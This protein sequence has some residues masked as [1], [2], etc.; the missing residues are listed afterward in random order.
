MTSP[1]LEA[2]DIEGIIQKYSPS[3]TFDDYKN[4]N[5]KTSNAFEATTGY[6]KQDMTFA[7]LDYGVVANAL[8]QKIYDSIINAAQSLKQAEINDNY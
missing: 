5:S 8:P 1:S 3:T 2:K 6:T 4:F 7:V